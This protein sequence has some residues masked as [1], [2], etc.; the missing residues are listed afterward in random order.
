MCC[1]ALL[2]C[3]TTDMKQLTARRL[4]SQTLQTTGHTLRDTVPLPPTL[5]SHELHV[6]RVLHNK[7]PSLTFIVQHL[8]SWAL[9]VCMDLI[10]I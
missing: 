3:T 9:H 6:Q 10:G 1:G 2:S 4:H 7:L 5:I 8:N